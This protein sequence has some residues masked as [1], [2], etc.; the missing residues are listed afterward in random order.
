ML[1]IP[2][3]H[4]YPPPE[5]DPQRRKERTL[6][7]L[8]DQLAS[9]AAGGSVLIILEDAHW[10]DP[11][12]L[13]LFGRA[14]LR[15][16]EMPVLLIMTCRP[17]FRARWMGHPQVTALV[18]NRLGRRHCRAIIESIAD[19][20]MPPEVIDQ[21]IAKTD[22]VP[23]FVEELTKTVLEL[24]LLQEK[25][26][27]WLLTEPLP[28]L[29]IPATLQDSLMARLDRLAS[30]KEVAQIGAT[31]GREFSY[32]VLAAVSA[33]RESGAQGCID[34]ARRCRAHFSP[35]R[36]ARG[37]LCLQARAGARRR[38]RDPAADQT[39]PA[40]RPDRGGSARTFP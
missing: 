10:A 5:P 22:G 24:G 33:M 4:R 25:E 16:P 13:D 20:T 9:M 29:A 37:E 30:V 39:A 11:T 12:T 1:S 3:E 21:I 40:S 34:Q 38:L 2:T 14:I 19:K 6:N 7:A 35:W 17:E 8:I 15:L 26:S 28:A 36:T 32:S 18:L 23:L 31:I 27:A